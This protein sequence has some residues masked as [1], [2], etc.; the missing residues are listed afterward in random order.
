M[1]AAQ[2]MA[3]ASVIEGIVDGNVPAY[4]YWPPPVS[5]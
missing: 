3:L 4:R 1:P 5:A 2:A